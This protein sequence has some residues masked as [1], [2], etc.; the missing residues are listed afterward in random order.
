LL[1]DGLASR[2]ARRFWRLSAR[3]IAPV[4]IILVLLNAIGLLP[5]LVARISG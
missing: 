5:F 2:L 1:F 3:Y 4:A